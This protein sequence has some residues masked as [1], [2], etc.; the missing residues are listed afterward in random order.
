GSLLLRQV[1]GL[2]QAG[3]AQIIVSIDGATAA[4]HDS[5][6]NTRGLFGK[7][8]EGLCAARERGI[9]TRVNT[10]VGPHNYAQMPQLQRLLT[11]CN[12][13]QWELSAIKLERPIA[14]AD[15]DHVRAICDALYEASPDT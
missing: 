6:R 4:T 8:I 3:L 10:V 12:V 14:Y 5:Y 11:E 15:P 13:R 9:L 7:A 2:A 1:D